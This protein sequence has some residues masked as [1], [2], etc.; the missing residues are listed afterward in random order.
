MPVRHRGRV[1]LRLPILFALLLLATGLAA[2]RAA[3]FTV[4][5]RTSP[6]SCATPPS[7]TCSADFCS[8]GAA[9]GSASVQFGDTIIVLPGTYY[10]NITMKNGVQLLGSGADVTIIDGCQLGPVVSFLVNGGSNTVLSGFTIRNGRAQTG[11]GIYMATRSGAAKNLGQQVITRN[12]IE[13]NTAFASGGFGGLGAGMAVYRQSPTI[14]NNI[15]RANTAHQFGA[16]ISI[17]YSNAV[18]SNNTLTGNTVVGVGGFGVG[19]GVDMYTHSDTPKISNN[20]IQANGAITGGG[21]YRYQ[22]SGSSSTVTVRTNSFFGNTGGT[23]VGVTCTGNGNITADAKFV[24]AAAGDLRLQGTSPAIDAGTDADAPASGKDLV[25]QI[26]ILDGNN[27]GIPRVD[28]GALEHCANDP[29]GDGVSNCTDNCRTVSNPTQTDSDGD[30]VGDACDNC[31]TTANASQADGDGDTVGDACDNC[32]TTPNQ[33]QQDTD[34]DGVGNACDNCP[35]VSNPTQADGDGDGVGNACDNCPTTANSSQ[36]DGDGDGVG[37]PCDN[38]PSVAN[39]NQADGDGDGVGDVCDNCPL[40]SNPSQSFTD[41]D[42]DGV[43]DLCDNCPGVTNPT[44]ADSDGDGIGN[45]CDNCAAVANPTQADGDGDGV[46][47]ACDNCVAVA[48]P[49]Q[50]DGDADGIGDAC[51][52]CPAVA[53][54]TQADADSDGAGDACDTCTDPDADGYGHPGATTCPVDN[55]PLVSNPSQADGDGDG[56]GDACDNCVAVANPGQED[57]DGDGLGSACDNCPGTANPAQADGDGDGVGDVCDTCSAVAN[58]GQEDP[59]ADGR[60][61]ACDNCPDVSNPSQLDF[62][63]D[64]MGDACDPDDDN[65]GVAD[66]GDGDGQVETSVCEGSKVGCDDC[67][68]L[69]ANNW[70][71]PG[72]VWVWW[73]GPTTLNWDPVDAGTAPLYNILRG[74]VSEMRADR[75]IL[76]AFCLAKDLSVMSRSATAIPSVP[77]EAFYFLLGAENGCRTFPA[78]GTGSNGTNRLNT[79]CDLISFP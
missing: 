56:V 22:Q 76:R 4:A 25:G 3:T 14:T 9:L 45:A 10:E 60:G 57:P 36:A 17:D 39:A 59:D 54:P 24:N 20:V 41:A 75:N 47:N 27:D 62:D 18:I 69:D 44:Q 42:A 74:R 19:G 70:A 65:D 28:M 64:G 77:N 35:T 48:N 63:L 29:D 2:P 78:W 43:N 37:D 5:P 6:G 13:G 71:I 61:S 73:S 67:A 7:G 23:C 11:A 16:G 26:R 40:V 32:L 38:C 66:D 51:D 8:I 12:I 53:N 55:C 30:G 15:F 1:N 79:A 50:A 21:I 52:N 34:G 58:P 31:P 33:T 72:D 68:R 46:G 49:T